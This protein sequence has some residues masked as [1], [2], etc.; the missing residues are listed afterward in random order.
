MPCTWSEFAEI[1]R[2]WLKNMYGQSK[3]NTLG[4][5]MAKKTYL[6]LIKVRV[7][8]SKTFNLTLLSPSGT[9]RPLNLSCHPLEDLLSLK[10]LTDL[11]SHRAISSRYFPTTFNIN[12]PY[13]FEISPY[14]SSILESILDVL[15]RHSPTFN[16]I[17]LSYRILPGLLSHSTAVNL[18]LP[19]SPG[20][21]RPCSWKSGPQCRRRTDRISSQ[22]G[23]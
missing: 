2:D 11:K 14:L 1:I 17:L 5:W 4:L 22:S 20:T 15:S 18:T 23:C 8:L 13:L 9:Q 16:L 10:I 7:Y 12:I 3:I 19:S 21:P 6:W